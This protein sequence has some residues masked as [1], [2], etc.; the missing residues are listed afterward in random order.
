M[1]AKVLDHHVDERA[2]V[3]PDQG[4]FIGS[5]WR[6]PDGLDTVQQLAPSR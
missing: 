2:I 3:Q 6:L 4:G 5:A 1:R